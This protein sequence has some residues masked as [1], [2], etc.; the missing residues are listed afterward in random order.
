MIYKLT[1]SPT[2]VYKLFMFL[3]T[4]Y[5]CK[6]ITQNHSNMGLMFIY[7][8]NYAKVGVVFDYRD[9]D[10]RVDLVRGKDTQYY[11]DEE[12]WVNIKPLAHLVIR[13]D[14]NYDI[15]KL[16]ME[17][18]GREEYYEVLI[19]NARVLQQYGA[20]FLNGREWI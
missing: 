3:I 14:S 13:H 16:S 4:E 1:D 17:G 9:N 6:L 19:E 7:Q 11:S 20:N 15:S 10:L 12:Y 18:R 2:L 8:N 5:G